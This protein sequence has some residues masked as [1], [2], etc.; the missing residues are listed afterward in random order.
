MLYR[1]LPRNG[2]QSG[3]ALSAIGLRLNW[4]MV[5][6]DEKRLRSLLETAIDNG[7]NSYYFDYMDLELWRCV[8]KAFE[9]IDPGL[10]YI[11]TRPYGGP[12]SQNAL[13]LSAERLN[14]R[15]YN[16]LDQ[17]GFHTINALIFEHYHQITSDNYSVIQH[18]CEQQSVLYLGCDAYGEQFGELIQEGD[19]PLLVTG[20]DLDTG[21][22]AR[23]LFQKAEQNHI[24]LLGTAFAPKV[25]AQ[26]IEAE[27]R[28]L[29]QNIGSLFAKKQVLEPEA[30]KDRY[31]FLY[32]I[33]NWEP[34][35]LCLAYSLN[36]S[37][38]NCFFVEVSDHERLIRLCKVPERHLPP[39][40][41]AQIEM[42]RFS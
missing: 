6:H 9:S 3:F 20:F 29:W 41:S 23:H 10:L 14:E 36:Q 11:V 4:K 24:A 18:Y 35:D 34:E 22:K 17:S 40:L 32:K 15:L 12:N 25:V 38:I 39:S 2:P 30:P 37:R 42:S 7:I 19:L 21:W 26:E 16:I 5:S 8:N 33:A 13:D 27:N 1:A 31:D 28:T